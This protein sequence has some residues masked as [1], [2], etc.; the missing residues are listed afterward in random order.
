MSV[1]FMQWIALAA[2]CLTAA[3]SP[4]PDFVLAVR[5]AL[6]YSRRIGLYTAAGFGLSLLVHTTYTVLGFAA[7]IAQSVFLFTLIKYAGAAYLFYLGVQALRSRGANAAQM[8]GTFARKD[9]RPQVTGLAALR[10]GFLTNL[11]NPKAS[12]FFLA[13]FSQ[14]VRP[15]TPAFWLVLYGLTCAAIVAG[16]FSLVACVLTVPK[17][18]NAFLKITKWIDKT[19][20]VLLIGLSVKVALSSK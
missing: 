13:V 11:L 14:I 8:D 18:R 15:D 12:L 4:G 2:V 7:L 5:N 17:T 1:Y 16:W 3:V 19:C 6:I 20:G 10:M 9:D